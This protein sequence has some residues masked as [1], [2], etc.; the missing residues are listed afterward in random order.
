MVLLPPEH[1]EKTAT[2][3]KSGLVCD[4]SH[5]ENNFT[6]GALKIVHNHMIDCCGS[7]QRNAESQSVSSIIVS[8]CRSK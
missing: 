6:D 7:F 8:V 5:P 3:V 2:I 4:F 1:K